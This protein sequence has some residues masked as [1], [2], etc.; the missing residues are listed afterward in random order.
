MTPDI[1]IFCFPRFA[2]MWYYAPT[3]DFPVDRMKPGFFIG[4]AD[5][6]G[7]GFSYMIVP[8]K[9][10]KDILV[11]YV[12]PIICQIVRLRDTSMDHLPV[13]CAQDNG[14]YDFV[15]KDGHSLP[16]SDL[17]DKTIYNLEAL[18]V[19]ECVNL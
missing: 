9:S 11:R 18:T 16:D 2:A 5:T 17:P 14:I 15:D 12:K 4:I 6:I 8:V 7:D 3:L 19:S 10:Y 1:S 13:V